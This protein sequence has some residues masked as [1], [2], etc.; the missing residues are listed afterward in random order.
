MNI[1]ELALKNLAVGEHVSYVFEGHDITNMQMDRAANKFGNALKKLGVALGDR[2]IMQMP[3]CPE[4]L[5]AFQAIWRIGAVAVP[6]N[7]LVGQEE[8]NFIYKDSGVH[9]VITSLDYL[10]KV[11]TAQSKS[12]AGKNI[13]V[14]SDKEIEGTHNFKKL[15]DESS[16]NLTMVQAADNDVATMIYTSGTTGTPKGVMLTNAGLA[17]SAYKQ[18]ESPPGFRR[19]WCRWPCCRFAIPSAW[20]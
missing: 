19:I 1:A 13:V 2:V 14:V 8:I 3:N 11:K 18:Q 12:G 10:D 5:Q 9:T 20:L 15:L 6:I 16:G 17:Y 4:V 7:Y